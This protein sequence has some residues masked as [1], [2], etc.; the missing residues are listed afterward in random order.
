MGP[1]LISLLTLAVGLLQIQPA[2]PIRLGIGA[3]SLAE[4]EI[5]EFRRAQ[6]G[7]DVWLVAGKAPFP[8]LS[9]AVYFAA[10]NATAELRRGPMIRGYRLVNPPGAWKL[11]APGHWA[12]VAIS[13][14]DYD[15]L[16][17]EMDVNLPFQVDGDFSDEELVSLVTWIRTSAPRRSANGRGVPL[18][19]GP[20]L[21]V[22]NIG[23]LLQ[24]SR[25]SKDAARCFVAGGNGPTQVLSVT[26]DAQKKSGDRGMPRDQPCARQI[27]NLLLPE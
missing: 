15:V 8:G 3:Q 17:G 2:V 5:S 6:P 10:E 12:Q 22:L 26:R 9:I 11:D 1:T 14:R 23:P 21:Q 24:V 7:R 18:D 27:L 4:E 13:G 19:V 16:N 20:V 25:T